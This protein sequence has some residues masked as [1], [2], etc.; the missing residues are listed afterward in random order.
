[1]DINPAGAA[2]SITKANQSSSFFFKPT[3]MKKVIFLLAAYFS[4]T[5]AFAQK[6]IVRDPNA[7]LRK[8]DDFHAIH[9]STGIRLYLNQGSE[10]AVA[11]SANS[12]EYR[13]RIQTEVRN[14]VLYIYYDTEKWKWFDL[15]GK[16]LQV[17][18]SCT[19]LDE[20]EGSSGAK[21]EVDGTL[22]SGKFTMSFTSGS[23][24]QGKVEATDLRVQQNSGAQSTIGGA[25]THLTASATSGSHLHG[26]DLVTGDCDVN[27]NSGGSI[28]ISV[29]K[30]MEVS[31]HSGGKVRYQ[32]NGVI[33]GVHTSS[34]GTVK[35]A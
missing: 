17:Y 3:I 9:V 19:T 15:N 6:T 2:A 12:A 29:E 26:F 32:G 31:A 25:A 24:F 23:K 5:A 10:K 20:L 4:F 14:G 30:E 16:G 1:V 8:V 18:V 13:D 34:G 35:K 21:V 33:R 22:K 11:V 7:V 28:E 27:A